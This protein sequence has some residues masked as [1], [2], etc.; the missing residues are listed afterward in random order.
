MLL[1]EPLCCPVGLVG[2]VGLADMRATMPQPVVDDVDGRD[3]LGRDEVSTIELVQTNLEALVELRR[4]GFGR[5]IGMSTVLVVA[6]D[7]SLEKGTSL[8]MCN[9]RLRVF[10]GVFDSRGHLILLF[11][12]LTVSVHRCDKPEPAPIGGPRAIYVKP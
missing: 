8:A 2:V 9:L 12:L 5:V 3:A 4:P 10:G 7:D 11:G 1:D 6:A